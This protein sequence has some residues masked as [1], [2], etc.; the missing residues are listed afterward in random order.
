MTTICTEI[1]YARAVTALPNA[2]WRMEYGMRCT[3]RP[4]VHPKHNSRVGRLC[5]CG[6]PEIGRA[7]V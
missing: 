7:H 4:C 3:T 1:R 5:G 2:L 6:A